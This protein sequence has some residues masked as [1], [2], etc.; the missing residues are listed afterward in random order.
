MTAVTPPP[1]AEVKKGPTKLWLPVVVAIGFLV[2]W[3]LSYEVPAPFGYWRFGPD[4]FRDTIILHTI[5]STVSIALILALIVIYMKVY[6]DT[7]ARFALGITV[8]FFALFIQALFQYPL[9]LGLAGPFPEGQGQYLSFGDLF[10]IAAYAV[11]LYLS[12]E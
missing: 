5:L 10:T 4:Q 6:A 11:F 2:G 7:G 8:V 9:L 1:A 12:L 3:A